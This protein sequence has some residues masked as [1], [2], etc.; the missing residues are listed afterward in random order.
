MYRRVDELL[1]PQNARFIGRVKFRTL[2]EFQPGGHELSE[3]LACLFL[4][5]PEQPQHAVDIDDPGGFG[6]EVRTVAAVR[7]I[8]RPS[9]HPGT[10]RVEVDVPH[11]LAEVPVRLAQHRLVPALEHMPYLLVL[12]VIVLAVAGQ[13]PVHDPP[14]RLRLPLDQQMNVVGHQAVRVDV[15]PKLPFPGAEQGQELVMIVGGVEDV[16]AVVPANDQMVKP[17]FDFEPRS[18]CHNVRRRLYPGTAPGANP[19]I[20][21]SKA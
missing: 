17:A 4:F 9:H 7:V 18:S 2:P 8:F 10:D 13:H 14:H 6:P 3:I 16:L 19:R 20:E 21:E 11:Q 15:E 12:P 5:R 1:G